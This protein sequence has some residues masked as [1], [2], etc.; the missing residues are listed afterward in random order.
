M[1]WK[2][3]PPEDFKSGAKPRTLP[4]GVSPIGANTSGGNSPYTTVQ[5][6]GSSGAFVPDV[7]IDLGIADIYVSNQGQDIRF[8]GKG[9]QTNV[10]ERIASTTQGM[11]VPTKGHAYAKKATHSVSRTAIQADTD[12]LGPYFDEDLNWL[13]EKPRRKVNRTK[14]SKKLPRRSKKANMASQMGG[15]RL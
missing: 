10:G 11:S 13:S 12:E 3:I 7:S 4:K 8:S 14:M 9:R 5:R 6:I 1:V 15:I 2:W